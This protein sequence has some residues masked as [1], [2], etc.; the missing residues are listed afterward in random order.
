MS[1]QSSGR[2]LYAFSAIK[3][4]SIESMGNMKIPRYEKV[5]ENMIVRSL[6]LRQSTDIFFSVSSRSRRCIDNV[7][8]LSPK[9]GDMGMNNGRDI[10]Q[11]V[12]A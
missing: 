12:Q 9:K 6:C 2:K 4:E 3:L 7:I 5:S 10:V 11:Y 8:D 1:R